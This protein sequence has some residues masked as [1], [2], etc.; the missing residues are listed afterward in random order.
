MHF[1]GINT[2][3]KGEQHSPFCFAGTDLTERKI[4]ISAV[5]QNKFKKYV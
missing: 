3:T 1:C 5:F 4:G 2:V